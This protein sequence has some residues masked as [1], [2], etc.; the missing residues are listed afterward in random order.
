MRCRMHIGWQLL[1]HTVNIQT[2]QQTNLDEDGYNLLLKQLMFILLLI[3]IY[4]II[5]IFLP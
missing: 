4:N 2:E 3:P 5:I 1:T